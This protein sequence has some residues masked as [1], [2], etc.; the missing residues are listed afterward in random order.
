MSPVKRALVID[1][2]E[3][4]R[5]FV[6]SFLEE[7][8]YECILPRPAALLANRVPEAEVV[9]LDLMMPEIDGIEVLRALAASK[10][11]A[12]V[13]LMSGIA[14]RVLETAEKTAR[15]LGLQ[16]AGSL[17][18]P[19]R[20]A[21]LKSLLETMSMVEMPSYGSGGGD[22]IPDEDLR[23]AVDQV[24]F[25]LYY[26]P[27]I[28]LKDKKVIGFEG[29]VRWNHPTRG[30]VSP[31]RFIP[32]LESMG[33]IRQ[34]GWIVAK[35]GLRDLRAL[36]SEGTESLT[37]SL[38]M[39]VHSLQDLSYP[40]QL[41]ALANSAGIDPARIVIEITESGLVSKIGSSLDV[42]TRLRMKGVCLSVDDF[43]TG[44]SMM[45]QL[46][47][48]PATELKIDRSF[49]AKMREEG[50]SRIMVEK[51]I[52]LAHQLE[53]LVVA[54]GVET[55]EQFEFLRVRGCDSAQGYLFCRPI[56]FPELTRWLDVNRV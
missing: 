6:V 22:D 49:V 9:I 24:E 56:P 17:Q 54:E 8:G 32:Q 46:R 27:Q 29:L 14:R 43:G 34:L 52:E 25:E 23:R 51:T 13:I 5:E 37:V 21:E 36:I 7:S 31:D 40:D 26:Q 20:L 30:V 55:P 38:N 47:N 39:S 28:R 42:L 16:V 10:S 3:D 50:S 1:D 35:Q 2:D 15:A 19:F 44:Y 41:V 33:L 48:V 11:Q 45:E 4:V 18:K 53:M 12:R